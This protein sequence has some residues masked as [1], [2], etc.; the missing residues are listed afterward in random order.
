MRKTR[1]WIGAVSLVAQ[2][3]LL[4][5]ALVY[6]IRGDYARAAFDVALAAYLRLCDLQDDLR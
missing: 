4:I 5:M 1:G 6:S 3:V 2:G